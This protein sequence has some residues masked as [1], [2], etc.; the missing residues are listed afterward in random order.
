MHPL[1]KTLHVIIIHFTSFFFL[2]ILCNVLVESVGTAMKADPGGY[3]RVHLQQLLPSAIWIDSGDFKRAIIGLLKELYNKWDIQTRL[4]LKHLIISLLKP[5][6]TASCWV[7][8]FTSFSKYHILWGLVKDKL[9]W[10]KV[11]ICQQMCCLQHPMLNQ[12]QS[13]WSECF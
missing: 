2:F 7:E 6:L 5:M 4:C 3:W 10:R 8:I 1:N 12:S 9:M 13:G 11:F